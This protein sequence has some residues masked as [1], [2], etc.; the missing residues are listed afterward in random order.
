MSAALNLDRHLVAG[1]LLELWEWVDENVTEESRPCTDSDDA[2]IPLGPHAAR[3]LDSLVGV[4]GFADAMSSAGWLSLRSDHAAFP[5]FFRHNGSSAKDRALAASRQAR[6][7]RKNVTIPSRA[8][9]DNT[10]TREEKRREENKDPPNPPAGGGG[11]KLKRGPE[12]P[13]FA[14]FW[15]AYPRKVAKAAAVRAF[16]KLG[17]DRG[18]LDAML[19]AIRVQSDSPG[20]T[21][22]GGAFVPHPASWLNGRRWE[23]EAVGPGQPPPLKKSFGARM[24]DS[25][26]LHP[27]GT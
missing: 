8:D 16:T 10:V 27:P 6:K 12:V 14:E 19:A 24:A 26:E 3:H 21:K 25:P 23:D 18:L 22:D 4:Q 1:L 20:W 9:R 13:L 11:G 17:P 5:N 15:A 2:M 7:R